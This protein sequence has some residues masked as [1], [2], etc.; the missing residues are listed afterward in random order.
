M[1]SNSAQ[2]GSKVIVIGELNVDLIFADSN[3]TPEPNRERLVRDFRLALGSSSAIAAAG[4]AGLGLDV[5]FVSIVGDDEFGHFCLKELAR[6]GVDVTHVAVDSSVRTGVTLSLTDGSDRSLLTYMGSIGSVTPAM[7]PMELFRE[8][9]H[10]HFG[11]YFLQDA[12]RPHWLEVFQLAKA[13]GMTTSF[14]AGWDPAEHWDRERLAALL[15]YTDWFIPSEEEA[16]QVFEVGAVD[17]LPGRLPAERGAVVVK[18]GSA[19]A[20]GI[21]ADGRVEYAP[22]F[23]VVPVDTTGAGDSFNAGFIAAKLRDEPDREAL[24]Y[25]NAC[26]ALSTLAIGGAG[27][28]TLDALARFWPEGRRLA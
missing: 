26:G 13:C 5:A 28:V 18:C 23:T 22:P 11:S 25:A 16:L 7:I 4:L 27:T 9:S 20:V 10:V 6:L 24:E 3:I 17:E 12:M 19:G 15:A 21:F 2:S 14:D 1:M 8:A